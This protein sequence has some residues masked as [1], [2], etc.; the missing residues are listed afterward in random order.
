MLV[1]Q[2]ATEQHKSATA[3]K[4]KAAKITLDAAQ[5]KADLTVQCLAQHPVK[6]KENIKGAQV[7]NNTS[8]LWYPDTK[9]ALHNFKLIA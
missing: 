5:K 8:I 1:L 6:L 4:Q 9:N 2:K 3:L 7:L